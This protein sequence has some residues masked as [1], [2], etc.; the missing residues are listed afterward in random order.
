MSRNNNTDVL[1]K[2]L[3][4]YCK[5][6]HDAHILVESLEMEAETQPIAH[7]F[8]SFNGMPEL[9]KVALNKCRKKVLD[10]GAGAGS[11]AL[12]LQKQN[13]DVTAL[14][15]SPGAIKVMQARGIQKRHQGY[16]SDL[17][18]KKYDTILLL[19]NG[20]GLAGR[21]DRLPIFLESL[22]KHLEPGGMILADSSD[23]VALY[24]QEDGSL[25]LPV[26]SYYGEVTFRYVFENNSSE[27]FPWL[28]VDPEQLKK[29]C[30]TIRCSMEIIYADSNNHFLVRIQ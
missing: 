6:N 27:W 12:W 23:I 14:D 11:H 15:P 4:A 20:L 5:G 17:P 26:H 18:P 8:R 10:V 29:A 7:F 9:E 28:F 13:R 16:V 19:M 3:W 2:A 21:L 30:H 22:K 25:M 24:E 1:G